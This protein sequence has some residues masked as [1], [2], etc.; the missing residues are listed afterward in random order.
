[1]YMYKLC[2]G[3]LHIQFTMPGKA[4]QTLLISHPFSTK[5]NQNLINLSLHNVHYISLTNFSIN[6]SD[7]FLRYRPDRKAHTQTH[8]HIHTTSRYMEVIIILQS[9]ALDIF[10][11]QLY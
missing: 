9:V 10:S 11:K 2:N 3:Q 4:R 6:T 8:T 1:M 5:F 7:I